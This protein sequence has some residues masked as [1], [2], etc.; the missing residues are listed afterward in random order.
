MM[1]LDEFRTKIDD[2][3]KKIMDALSERMTLMEDLAEYK[4]YHKIPIID[5]KRE[6]E[7]LKTVAAEAKKKKL[8]K[9]FVEQIFENILKESKRVQRNFF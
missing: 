1:G 4:K 8:D 9:E 2:I 7:L 6:E 3:D 5:T